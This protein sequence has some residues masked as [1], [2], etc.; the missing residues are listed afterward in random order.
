MLA[1]L[2][3]KSA[4]RSAAGERAYRRG[5]EYYEDGAV[6]DLVM[7][8]D[9]VVAR[10]MGGDEYA[11]RLWADEKRLGYHCT[12]PVGEDGV[13]C[14]HA[15]AAG[16]AWLDRL[17]GRPPTQRVHDDLTDIRHWLDAAPREQLAEILFDQSLTDDNLRTRLTVLAVRAQEN[18]DLKILK[19]AVGRALSV[20]GFIGHHGMRRLLARA[21][22]AVELIAGL[23]EDGHAA[24]AAELATYALKR[25][26]TAYERTD[27]SGGSFRDLLHDIMALHLKACRI[28][29]PN[30]KTFGKQLF[31]LMLR[32]Q[33]ALLSFEDYA[34]LL[35][36]SGLDVL[37]GKAEKQW[38]KVPARSPEKTD[39]RNCDNYSQI[40]RIMK[41]L[42]RYSADV[43]ALVAVHARDLTHPHHFVEIAE[44]L[45][46]AGRLDDALAWAE[47]G[48][49]AFAQ[50]LVPQLVEFLTEEYHRRGRH[51]DA[52]A[53]AWDFFI[54]RPMLD[55]YMQL[56]ASAEEAG[57]WS[58][59]R[60]K[61]LAWIRTDY[62]PA[63][64][65][66]PARWSW[67]PGA[68]SLLVEI[69]LWEG[70]S[71]TALAEAKSSGCTENLWFKL[72]EA[73]EKDHPLQAAEIYRD[74]IDA[75]VNKKS[76][77]AYNEATTLVTKIRVLMNRA[78]KDKEFAEWLDGVRIRHKTKRNFIQRLDEIAATPDQDQLQN[79]FRATT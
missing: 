15:V 57:S 77:D 4:L 44:I 71:D 55:T 66:N 36:E 43:D 75:I 9:I 3:S 27:D 73:R 17:A 46:R 60:D 64:K 48:K 49:Q 35:G 30:A 10:V 23:I 2:L 74:R 47:R 42:A 5:M 58:A 41:A 20:S 21:Y 54:Q 61:A 19:Q 79:R 51:D 38:H 72:A 24:G 45:A 34:P 62:L 56:A 68:R 18:V 12:C 52:V 63:V 70:D 65:R 14:K 40:T 59:R 16:L 6:I 13:F 69:F 50:T 39:A 53:L 31:D 7:T 25:G 29:P 67:Q 33:W 78:K 11:V 32:D 22:P 37:R 76:N 26:L 28:A 8:G 1:D